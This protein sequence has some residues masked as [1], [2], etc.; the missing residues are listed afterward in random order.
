M[1]RLRLS[2][3]TGSILLPTLVARA[4]DFEFFEKNIRPVL[5]ENCYKCHSATSEKLKGGLLL[6][7]KDGLLKGGDTGPAIVPGQPDK[8]LLIKAVRYTDKD[9]QMPPKDKRLAAAHIDDLVTWVKMGAPDPRTNSDKTVSAVKPAYDFVAA[10]KQWAFHKPQDPPAPAVK[11]KK[12]IKSPIDNFI[13]A[14]LEEKHLAPARPADKLTLIRRATFD[15]TGLPPTPKEVEDFL[16]DKSPDA[17]AKVVDRLLASPHYGERWGRHWLDV[18]RYADSLDSRVTGGEADIPESYRYRDWVVNAFNQDMPYDQ[19]VREQIAGDLL[20]PKDPDRIDTNGIIATG[21]Y[22]IGNWGNGD[23][24]KDK[25]LT[26]IADDQVDVTGR[27]F[28]GLTLACARCHDHKFDPIPTAD[29]YSLA[30]IFFSSH[31]LP[32]LTPKGQGE[33][34]LF[35]P[36]A[37]PGE[38]D[39]RQKREARM[40]ELDKEIT[41]IMDEQL[42]AMAKKILSQSADYLGA[43]AAYR[44]RPAAQSKM[45]IAEFAES[46]RE[47]GFQPAPAMLQRW[48]DYL[49]FGDVKLLSRI[50]HDAL[51]KPGLTTLHNANDADTPSGVINATDKVIAFV[52]ITMPPH[53][54]AIHPSPTGG[55][56]A[57]WVSPITGT[58]EITGRVAD[59]DPNCGDGIDWQLE[60]QGEHGKRL[61]CSGA[62]PNGGAQAF[63]D[64]NGASNL[65]AVKISEGEMLSLVVGPKAEYSCD[66]TVVELELTERGGA[67]RVWNLTKDVIAAVNDGANPYPD[68]LGN[69]AVWRIF[70]AEGQSPAGVAVAGSPLAK[71]YEAL[72]RHA[73]KTELTAAAMEIQQA[74][75]GDEFGGEQSLPGFDGHQRHVLGGRSGRGS[76]FSGSGAKNAF[77]RKRTRTGGAQE[78]CAADAR[79][80]ARNPG[81]RRAGQSARGSPRRENSFAREV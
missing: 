34:L 27:A 1:R 22:A 5:V 81:R 50:T 36:L 77:W 23:A 71:W 52:T 76:E 63:S 40:A 28:L 18:V 8:S 56:A 39:R 10:R 69:K 49:G 42:A 62:I 31:I 4:D 73:T 9:L 15:L 24:D 29:Y 78:K 3:L 43:V 72:N 53:T 45:S 7:T 6:D 55:V 79:Q 58:V 13:E 59:A 47:E 46:F 44:E 66:T 51:D 61:L 68:Q 64:G 41:T 33:N 16:R 67:K 75:T 2:I 48:V 65:L 14:K 54:L 32:K 17:F 74:L 21:M 60:V 80:S 57:G 25:I 38:L 37:S 12:W 30:G 26:D 35:I 70:D 11:N 20:Q 19:F